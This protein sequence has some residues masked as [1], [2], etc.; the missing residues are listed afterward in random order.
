MAMNEYLA[1]VSFA[2]PAA[3][4]SLIA[5]KVRLVLAMAEDVPS[6]CM[7]VCRMDEASGLCEGCLRTLDEIAR[8]SALPVSGKR[9]VWALIGQRVAAMQEE[10]P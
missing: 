10:K 2:D 6:P 1:N 3:A 4:T 9:E 8:W 5:E 7:G